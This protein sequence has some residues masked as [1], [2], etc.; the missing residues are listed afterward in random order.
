MLLGPIKSAGPRR[1]LASNYVISNEHVEAQSAR[2]RG[3][4]SDK[5]L[6]VV[7]KGKFPVFTALVGLA[8]IACIFLTEFPYCLIP[9]AVFLYVFLPDPEAQRREAERR[10]RSSSFRRSS[11]QKI[12]RS[13]SVTIL[14]PHETLSRKSDPDHQEEAAAPLARQVEKEPA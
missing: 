8:S 13:R 7:M 1:A 14:D 12:R 11:F 3:G 6:C 9:L 5:R 10:A 4:F 2:S